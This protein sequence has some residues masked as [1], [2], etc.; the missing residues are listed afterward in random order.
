MPFFLSFRKL[1]YYPFMEYQLSESYQLKIRSCISAIKLFGG[2]NATVLRKYKGHK[3][4]DTELSK[5]DVFR[6]VL[7][8]NIK[9]IYADYFDSKCNLVH[10]MDSRTKTEYA[11]DL[12]LGWLI[13]DAIVLF[14]KKNKIKNNLSGNDRFREF[15]HPR[16][17]STQPDILI[18]HKDEDRLLE[19]FC[20]WKSTWK[21]KGHMDLRDSKFLKLQSKKA[22]ML[23]VAPQTE[24]GLIIDF[25]KKNLDFKYERYIHGYGGKPGY[26]NTNVK[27]SL[28]PLGKIIEKLLKKLS[29]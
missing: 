27:N 12:I 15:L 2:T 6:S 13:E 9:K 17:I 28:K 8:S 7:E 25:K 19:I 16:K 24:E 29:T 20:D 14:L 22:I 18:K 3:F 23:C 1:R 4:V 5:Q 10:H 11:I 21:K 26:T